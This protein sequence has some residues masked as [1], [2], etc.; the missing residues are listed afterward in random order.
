[1]WYQLRAVLWAC[2]YTRVFWWSTGMY[3]GTLIR[4]FAGVGHMRHSYWNRDMSVLL[5]FSGVLGKTSECWCGG[6]YY[7]GC[8]YLLAPRDE[9]VSKKKKKPCSALAQHQKRSF[10]RR[11]WR[12]LSIVFSGLSF[13][14]SLLRT[15]L[16][17]RNAVCVSACWFYTKLEAE[18][19]D[20]RIWVFCRNLRACFCF[21]H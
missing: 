16:F 20:I 6:S 10:Q 19:T 13:L 1:M 11:F 5:L 3:C 14:S 12:L 18:T 17:N 21:Y 8:N 7:L 15:H 4:Y 9:S 2:N